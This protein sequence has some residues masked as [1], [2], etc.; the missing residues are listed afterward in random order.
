MFIHHAAGR[1]GRGTSSSI[2]AVVMRAGHGMESWGEESPGT[3]KQFTYFMQ[4]WRSDVVLVVSAGGKVLEWVQ[5]SAYGVPF[6]IPAGDPT[7]AGGNSVDSITMLMTWIAA[8]VYDVRWDINADGAVTWAD[9]NHYP[10][11]SMG[12]GVLSH[13]GNRFGYA[14]Y[15][16]APELAGARWDARVAWFDASLGILPKLPPGGYNQK[17]WMAC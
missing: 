4:N 7:S 9:Y 8:G 13:V 10:D 5:Y 3:F 15:Q 12:R 2:D 17:L 6:G 1:A 16:H 11:I 14:G